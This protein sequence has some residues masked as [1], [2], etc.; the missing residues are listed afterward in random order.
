MSNH[1]QS[2]SRVPSTATGNSSSDEPTRPLQFVPL[3]RA[4]GIA[5]FVAL[6]ISLS[7]LIVI[8]LGTL[9]VRTILFIVNQ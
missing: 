1:Q 5:S 7:W 4:L 6:A 2:T 8:A 3:P 9:A